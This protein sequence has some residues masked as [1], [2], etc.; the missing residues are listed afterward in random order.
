M[1]KMTP[2]MLQD[3]Q[4]LAA[5]AAIDPN[6]EDWY[7]RICRWYSK[8]C[9]TPLHVVMGMDEEEVI[10]VYFEDF[11]YQLSQRTDDNGK[12]AFEAAV[13]QLLTKPEDLQE[14]Q[15]EDDE[16]YK[17]EIARLNADSS[18]KDQSLP[19]DNSEDL[20]REAIE[21]AKSLNPNLMGDL[22]DN[23]FVQGEDSPTEDES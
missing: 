9:T 7:R 4:I 14:E 2:Q 17:E 23:I 10:K 19:G 16:W 8:E 15:S 20:H 1:S 18:K 6:F 12:A 3:I 21:T 13:D 5:K 11:Y 22:P